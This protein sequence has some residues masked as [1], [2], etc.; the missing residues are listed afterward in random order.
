MT[1]DANYSC[2]NVARCERSEP[3]EEQE[4]SQKAVAQEQPA[5]SSESTLPMFLATARK[6]L[7]ACIAPNDPRYVQLENLIAGGNVDAVRVFLDQTLL[8]VNQTN[9]DAKLPLEI[10]VMMGS[11]PMMKLLM[12]RGARPTAKA[13]VRVI[14]D[15]N[16]ISLL[17]E[18]A[19]Q[20]QTDEWLKVASVFWKFLPQMLTHLDQ[21]VERGL[22]VNLKFR[23]NCSFTLLGRAVRLENE[24]NA[25]KCAQAL[26]EKGADVNGLSQGYQGVYFGHVRLGGQST[27]YTSPVSAAIRRGHV[28]LVK[29]LVDSGAQLSSDD[30][31]SF[32]KILLQKGFTEEVQR[33]AD[34]GIRLSPD[35]FIALKKEIIKEAFEAEKIVIIERLVDQGI[36]SPSDGLSWVKNEIRQA[37]RNSQSRKVAELIKLKAK[38]ESK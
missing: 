26:V 21:L 13:F 22:D 6:W 36:L 29:F 12:E 23:D 20:M 37:I 38:L 10:A 7:P 16:L 11:T 18:G 15:A 3:R 27:A 5:A 1:I 24:G 14:D 34:K 4:I 8:D 28:Q 32:I 31:C 33:L 35:R 9:W 2:L 17:L 19:K 30:A 25:L